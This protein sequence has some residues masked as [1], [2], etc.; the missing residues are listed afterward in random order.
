MPA[1]EA[2]TDVLDRELQWLHERFKT[3]QIITAFLSNAQFKQPLNI[4]DLV[5]DA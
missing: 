1:K 2:F 5:G 4:A 3:M